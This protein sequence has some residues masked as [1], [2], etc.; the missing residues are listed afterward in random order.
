MKILA[1]LFIMVLIPQSA[2]SEHS[3]KHHFANGFQNY[4]LV[5]SPPS[6]GPGFYLDRIWSSFFLPEVPENHYLP[7][8]QALNQFQQLKSKNTLT[9]IGQSTFLIKINEKTILTDPFFSD[10]A[11]PFSMGPKRFVKPGISM[12]NL[13]T[14]DIMLISHNHYDHLDE[15]FVEELPGKESIR[16]FVPLGLKSFF[17]E[18]G[19]IHVHELDWN[20]SLSIFDFKITSLPTVHFSGRGLS[21]KNQTLWC[22]WSITSPS[23]KYYFAGDTAYSPTIFKQIGHKFNSFD[24]AMLT[25]GTYG[26]RKYGVNN[27]TTP[28][29]AINIGIEI[30]ATTF[31]GMHWGTIEMSDEPTLEPAKRF[32][33]AGKQAGLSEEQVW[34]MKIG[35]T[36]LLPA[37]AGYEANSSDK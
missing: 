16:V 26:N 15:G 34:I 25:I 36:R 7:E 9:W 32:R 23:G 6:L 8:E 1:A 11:G 24:L 29:E 21:D 3:P 18:R 37:T 4:P 33:E 14:I 12:R 31:V 30:G 28:E 22:S 27:H 35:E 20:E 19:Y 2:L 17:T 10:Y 13:P 5:P